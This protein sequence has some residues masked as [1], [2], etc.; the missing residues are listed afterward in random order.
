ML[1]RTELTKMLQTNQQRQKQSTE[2]GD[3][4][5]EIMSLTSSSKQA[6][7]KFKDGEDREPAKKTSDSQVAKAAPKNEEKA[8]KDIKSETDPDQ[9]TNSL[10]QEEVADSL[11][12]KGIQSP[13]SLELPGN[14]FSQARGFKE[15]VID[16][17]TQLYSIGQA[18]SA[19]VKTEP[20]DLKKQLENA[21]LLKPEI[22]DEISQV[23]SELNSQ[24]LTAKDMEKSIRDLTGKDHEVVFRAIKPEAAEGKGEKA[25]IGPAD[26]QGEN[27]INADIRPGASLEKAAEPFEK[28]FI[29]V[30]DGPEL[31]QKIG[32]ELRDKIL[33]SQTGEKSYELNLNP[34]SLGK[35]F[36]KVSVENG[37]TN[38]EMHFT[39]KKTLEL[40]KNNGAELA[41]IIATNRGSEVTV[42]M[43]E[44][45]RP[46]Y[47]Q[48]D[49]QQKNS[50]QEQRQREEQRQ[51]EEFILRL[52]DS[53]KQEELRSNRG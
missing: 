14:S 2:K 29:K 24:A 3:L 25:S 45:A 38:L 1:K 46:D 8:D 22:R 35:I 6:K 42:R 41:N 36:V 16:R 30:S 13:G 53:I 4:F 47:L 21:F 52:K 26:L 18:E 28:I 44:E 51:S 37:V 48:Q 39:N 32:K 27:Q 10:N 23:K 19:P 5:R 43:T 33:I 7:P 20:A 49:T 34:G 50:S 17:E 11:I 40:M 31:T 9:T 12:D 15:I